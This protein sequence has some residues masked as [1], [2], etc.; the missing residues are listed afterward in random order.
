MPNMDKQ[1]GA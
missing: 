1:V